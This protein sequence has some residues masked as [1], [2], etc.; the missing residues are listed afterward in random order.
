MDP[1][2]RLITAAIGEIEAVIAEH[3][4]RDFTSFKVDV[5]GRRLSMWWKGPLPEIFAPTLAAIGSRGIEVVVAEA[6]Y[7]SAQLQE[8]AAAFWETERS[9]PAPY[10]AQTVASATDGSGLEIG[11]L[12]INAEADRLRAR[13]PV[14]KVDVT[15]R[16]VFLD[17]SD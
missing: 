16:T 5:P 3:D 7:S 14:V 12:E 9:I 8:L 17:H 15:G 10:R 11:V 6:R 1:Q 4:L 13:F 2:E